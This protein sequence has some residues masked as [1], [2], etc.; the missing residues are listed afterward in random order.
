MKGKLIALAAIVAALGV[1]VGTGAFTTVAAD[2]TAEVDVAGDDS[3][4]VGLNGLDEITNNDDGDFTLDLEGEGSGGLNDEGVTDFGSVL[5]IANNG[6]EEV[7]VYIDLATQDVNPSSVHFYVEDGELSGTPGVASLDSVA[8]SVQNSAND[9]LSD[10]S[11]FDAGNR[12]SITY[13]SE[14]TN[15]ETLGVTLGA[16]DA[17]NVGLLID[18][19]EQDLGDDTE[20]ISDIT[21]VADDPN[22][23]SNVDERITVS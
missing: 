17:V 5:E 22:D 1:V 6:Q 2:R 21:V 18:L 7:T 13:D 23:V 14:T 16:G 10:R 8:A 19:I 15:V 3:A 4:L 11:M 9:P 20:V 12:Y